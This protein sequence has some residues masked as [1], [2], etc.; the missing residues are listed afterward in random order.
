MADKSKKRSA[1]D[2][3]GRD[4]KRSYRIGEGSKIDNGVQIAHN[5]RLGKRNRVAAGAM[6]AGSV[7]C[8]DDVWVGPMVSISH[9]LHVGDRANLTMGSV[10]TKD[11]DDDAHLTGNF[12]IDHAKFIAF[13]KSVR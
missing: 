4:G 10:V 13:L 12:A 3:E 9:M 2:D 7:E 5:A 11:V 8:G 6:V 1:S